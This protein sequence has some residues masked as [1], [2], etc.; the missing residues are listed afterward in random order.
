[1]IAIPALPAISPTALRRE[2]LQISL[3]LMESCI[4]T[5]AF[6]PVN[7]SSLR[8][9]PLPMWLGFAG[10][11]AF[12][13]LSTRWIPR[14]GLSLGRQ[15]LVILGL[16]LASV[17]L[18]T[19]FHVH[20]Y[21]PAGSGEW[22][23]VLFDEWASIFNQLT[24]APIT[25][26]VVLIC[27]WR[28]IHLVYREFTLQSVSLSFRIDIL[29]MVGAG[30]LWEAPR[31]GEVGLLIYGFFFFAILSMGLARVDEI[32]GK[33][34]GSAQP[35]GLGWLATMLGAG[36]VVIGLGW[37]VARVY[38]PAGFSALGEWLA[39]AFSVLE[40]AAYAILM[41]LGRLLEPII[42]LLV[43][44]LEYLIRLAMENMG[45]VMPQDFSGVMPTPQPTE[46]VEGGFPWGAVFKWGTIVSLVL[47]ALLGVALSLRKLV[48]R[49]DDK[50]D[51]SHRAVLGLNEWRDDLMENL[52]AGADRLAEMLA[53]LTGRGLGMELY[54]ELSIRSIYASMGRLAGRRGFPR[55]AAITPYEYLP[56]LEQAFPLAAQAD[57]A[58]ITDAYV[59]VHYGEI[60][61][62]LR[63]V[64]EIRQAWERV[65]ASNR[66]ADLDANDEDTSLSPEA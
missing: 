37:I 31:A 62:T 2:L 46:P 61:S 36:L 47:V 44:F 30:L 18:L 55:R 63:E 43:R 24:D 22:P 21:V 16:I 57:L 53:A 28:G 19:R 42:S 6:I 59:G 9:A 17:A 41:F 13:Y 60:P 27:W 39:P 15:R 49:G 14:T 51:A 23:A 32:A 45:E 56:A 20:A 25:L 12:A 58:H 35:F 1:M 29:W 4:I 7:T 50:G 10:L 5:A 3:L 52:R 8:H 33:K 38:S 11:L 66:Q 40:Q 64:Q 34:D 48:P 54:A 65:R 26:G